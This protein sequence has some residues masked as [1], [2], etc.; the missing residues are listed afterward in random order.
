MLAVAS[1]CFS[2]PNVADSGTHR[3]VAQGQKLL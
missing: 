3:R 2:M 1:I